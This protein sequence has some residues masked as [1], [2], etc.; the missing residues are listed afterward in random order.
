[1]LIVHRIILENSRSG[2]IYSLH[3]SDETEPRR[4]GVKEKKKN[5]ILAKVAAITPAQM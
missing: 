1:M 4:G 3:H 5:E 2:F